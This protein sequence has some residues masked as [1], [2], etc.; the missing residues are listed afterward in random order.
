MEL[1]SEV[2]SKSK[3]RISQPQNIKSSPYTLIWRKLFPQEKNASIL[4]LDLTSL[5]ILYDHRDLTI[6]FQLFFSKL[7]FFIL[8]STIK[9]AFIWFL[10]SP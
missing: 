2:S 6:K 3:S 7:T 9:A 10:I 8:T 4:D 5:Q 1:K